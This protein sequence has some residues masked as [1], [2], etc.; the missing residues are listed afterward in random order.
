MIESF[1]FI[2]FVV[3]IIGV[4][5]FTGKRASD[6]KIRGIGLFL[7]C[8]GG[9]FYTIFC[10]YL[11]LYWFAITQIIFEILDIRGILN[12]YHEL[13]GKGV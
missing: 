9:V 1:E 8:I 2:S 4:I 12:C 3:F 13:K 5:V 7:Y 6:P 11:N 10:L